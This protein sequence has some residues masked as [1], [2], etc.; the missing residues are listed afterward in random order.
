VELSQVGAF[1]GQ[2]GHLVAVDAGVF[3]VLSDLFLESCSNAQML[4]GSDELCLSALVVAVLACWFVLSL[5][6]C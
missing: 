6:V 1:G 2:I 4:V 5:S 3:Q